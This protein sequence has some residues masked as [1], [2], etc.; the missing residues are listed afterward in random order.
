M[1]LDADIST[2]LLTNTSP[3]NTT[4]ID[5]QALSLTSID[6]SICCPQKAAVFLKSCFLS[7]QRCDIIPWYFWTL[8]VFNYYRKAF[9]VLLTVNLFRMYRQRDDSAPYSL[10]I[11]SGAR[12]SSDW[13]S[14][15][16][17]KNC[18]ERGHTCFFEQISA[19]TFKMLSISQSA[20]CLYINDYRICKIFAV[21]LRH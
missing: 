6:S 1:D 3:T 2:T 18:V 4:A 12:C 7:K 10:C 16:D 21:E 9:L 5:P 13:F 11:I 19:N 20:R 15:R 14:L 17:C 8:I